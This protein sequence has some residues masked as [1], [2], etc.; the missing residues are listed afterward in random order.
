MAGIN[1][2]ML[3][4]AGSRPHWNYECCGRGLLPL[5]EILRSVHNVGSFFIFF[6]PSGAQCVVVVV[7]RYLKNCKWLSVG[8]LVSQGQVCGK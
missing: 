6:C 1:W 8:L 3:T 2:E 7:V 4:I 5:A